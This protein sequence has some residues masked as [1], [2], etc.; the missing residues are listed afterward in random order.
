M[1]MEVGEQR[2]GLSTRGSRM[3][4]ADK[5][6]GWSG[7]RDIGGREAGVQARK[8]LGPAFGHLEALRLH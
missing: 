7:Q 5:S 1:N 2:K 3:S 4:R 8:S 6:G